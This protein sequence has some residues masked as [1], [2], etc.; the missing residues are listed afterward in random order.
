MPELV[1][2]MYRLLSD[3]DHQDKLLHREQ[4]MPTLKEMSREQY[5]R[6]H[7]LTAKLIVSDEAVDIFEWVVHRLIT[8]ALCRRETPSQQWTDHRAGRVAKQAGLILSLLAAVG[9]DNG[10]DPIAPINGAKNLGGSA[11]MAQL[12]TITKH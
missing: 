6:F 9:A 1:P 11:P 5:Q 7:D 8:Q 4:A 3:Q 2:N 10:D 12:G